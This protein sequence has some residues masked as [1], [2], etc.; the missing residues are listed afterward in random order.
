MNIGSLN[1]AEAQQ[2]IPMEA[3]PFECGVGV[4]GNQIPGN[5]RFYR[6][7]VDGQRIRW[8][9]F[10]VRRIFL[11]AEYKKDLPRL[12]GFKRNLNLV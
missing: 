3:K 11:I 8:I 4:R 1:L 10:L 12:A 7:L 9:E 2:I 5:D 6:F